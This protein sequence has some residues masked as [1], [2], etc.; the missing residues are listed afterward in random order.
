MRPGPQ[1]SK[2]RSSSTLPEDGEARTGTDGGLAR[3]QVPG[4]KM[5]GR[6]PGGVLD[7]SALGCSYQPHSLSSKLSSSDDR[8]WTSFG[9]SVT[10][11]RRCQCSVK[12]TGPGDIPF[13]YKR[14]TKL[15]RNGSHLGPPGLPAASQVSSAPGRW[16]RRTAPRRRPLARGAGRGLASTARRR[17]RQDS[18]W[19][20][21]P[22]RDPLAVPP[23]YGFLVLGT[24]CGSNSA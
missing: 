11:H 13:V 9:T 5:S 23:T 12:Q 21:P 19:D 14:G 10:K 2:P 20:R 8:K 4:V 15:S 1:E 7:V 16:A 3:P 18:G 22:H 24:M 17:R 6:Q